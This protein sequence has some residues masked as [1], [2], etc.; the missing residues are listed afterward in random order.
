MAG[1]EAR[2]ARDDECEGRHAHRV[3]KH[4]SAL[5]ER[6]GG[7]AEEGDVVILREG[8]GVERV[9]Q[10]GGEEPMHE[11]ERAEQVRAPTHLFCR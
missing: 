3:E 4:F 2:E 6:E 5:Q 7:V 1:V 11:Q 10:H 8:D 9:G